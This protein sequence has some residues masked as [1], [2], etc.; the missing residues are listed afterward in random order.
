[1]SFLARLAG[2]LV[3][4]SRAASFPG[5]PTNL[6]ELGATP[7]REVPPDTDLVGWN[8]A[9]NRTHG[10]AVLAE[11]PNL[12]VRWH[13][14]DR[15][16]RVLKMVRPRPADLIV[17]VGCERGG[18]SSRIAGSSSY[19]VCLDIDFDVLVAAREQLRGRRA[20]LVVADAQQLPF[21]SRRANISISSHT[22]EHLPDPATGLQ[23]LAR[24]TG[25]DGYLVINVP[26]DRWMLVLKRIVFRVLGGAR[27]F[28]GISPGLAPGHLWVFHPAL[29]RKICQGH[30]R[31]GRLSFNFPFF[32]NIFV[33]A[34]PLT[35][36]SSAAAPGG[37]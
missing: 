29:L 28:G 7:F 2:R 26:N 8:R 36:G 27:K 19:L 6:A 18:L 4:R 32:T 25:P 31:L 33:T 13:E 5:P 11:H 37:R 20:G 22:L 14:R 24:I 10:M 12:L 15:K 3:G 23:E 34:R 9:L 17:E 30:V 16:R 21:K 35:D 1:M